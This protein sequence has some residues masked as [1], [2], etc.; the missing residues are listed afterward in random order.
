MEVD[1]LGGGAE[2]ALA[3]GGEGDG[4]VAEF[5]VTL[6][7]GA[8]GGTEKAGEE[9]VAKAYACELEVWLLDP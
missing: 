4:A 9:L 3:G 2:E 1:D 5:P 7:G 6:G 8:D